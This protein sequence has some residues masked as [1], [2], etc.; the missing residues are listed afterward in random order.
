MVLLSLAQVVL[1]VLAKLL[2]QGEI[3]PH[4]MYV[5]GVWALQR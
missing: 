1:L 2:V 4:N 3:R 5:H